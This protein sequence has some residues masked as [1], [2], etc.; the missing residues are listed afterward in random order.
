MVCGQR[1]CEP[2]QEQRKEVNRTVLSRVLGR[3][4][5]I[6][7]GFGT[8]IGWASIV[9]LT[10]WVTQAGFFGALLAFGSGA[11]V[12]LMIGLCYGELTSA[13][14]L[15]GGEMVFAY[16]AGGMTFGWF[17]GW[18]MVLAYL[19]VAVW[20]GIALAMALDYLLPILEKIY[21]W[22]VAGSPEIGRAHV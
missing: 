5:I 22:D 15:S 13:L 1:K 18:M 3:S 16:R 17:A 21:L 8:M 10:T 7:L 6:A 4:D 20:E 9:M 11:V 12:I 19:G 2:L 14:P